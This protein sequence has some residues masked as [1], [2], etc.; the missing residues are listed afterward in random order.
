MGAKSGCH[1]ISLVLHPN[2]CAYA[3]ALLKKGVSAPLAYIQTNKWAQACF[4][5]IATTFSPI[6]GLFIF[7]RTQHPST[8]L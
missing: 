6:I 7:P 1:S 8:I 3:W 4:P 2:I 5:L